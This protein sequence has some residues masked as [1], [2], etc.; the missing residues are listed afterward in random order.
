MEDLKSKDTISVGVLMSMGALVISLCSLV[1]TV[2]NN[3]RDQIASVR[4]A[5]VFVYS[6]DSGWQIQNIGSGPA[7]NVIISQNEGSSEANTGNWVK[8][9]RIPP[10]KKDG[11]FSLHWMPFSNVRRLGATYDDMWGRPYTTTCESDLNKIQSGRHLK[12]WDERE[13]VA[14]WKMPKP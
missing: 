11:F 13:V 1:Y 7:L 6:G 12:A 8:P 9:V 14:D 4:P 3:S 10:L 5:I 2:M